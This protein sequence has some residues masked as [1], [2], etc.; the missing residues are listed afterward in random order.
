MKYLPDHPA[1]GGRAFLFNVINSL[2]P[3]YFV[4]AQGEV[5]RLRIASAVKEE[6]A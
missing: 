3:A 6:S 5:E 4:R 2:D 1:A